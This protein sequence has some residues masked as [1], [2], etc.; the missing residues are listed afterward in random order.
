M[1][2]M[3][4]TSPDYVKGKYKLHMLKEVSCRATETPFW[5]R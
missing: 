5:P 2:R 1:A 3:I 4:V